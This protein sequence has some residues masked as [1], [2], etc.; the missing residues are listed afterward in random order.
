MEIESTKEE[1]MELFIK[2]TNDINQKNY[3]EA[4]KCF[5]KVIEYSPDYPYAYYSLAL[6]YELKDM[7]SKAIEYY[8]LYSILSIS[9]LIKIMI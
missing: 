1:G 3:D 5:E 7:P 4:I 8:Y 6:T 9:Y 2:L